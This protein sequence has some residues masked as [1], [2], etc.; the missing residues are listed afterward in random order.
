MIEREKVLAIYMEGHSSD[1]AGKMGFG[2]LRYSA[3]PVACVVDSQ[4]A[5]RDAAEVTGIPRPCPI[6]ATIAEARARGAEVLVLGIAPPGGRIPAAWL[7]ALDAAVACGFSL[8]NGLHDRLGPR[9]PTLAA[10][11]WVWDIRVEPPG[12]GIA[13]GAAAKST[14]RRVV[15]VGTDMAI[16]K[17]TA[18]LELHAAALAR[19]L[20]SHFVATGQIGITITGRGVPLDAIRL[21]FA[22]GAVE[23]EVLAAGD[24]AIVF[25]E[26]QGSLLHPAS[27]ATLPLLRGAMPTHLVLCHRA[28]QTHLRRLPE[29]VIP[30]LDRVIALYR[31]VAAACGAFP[32]PAVPCVALNTCEVEADD[33]ARRAADAI[34]RELGLPCDDPLRHGPERLLESLLA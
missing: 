25:V 19:G 1:S 7:A 20:R 30:P 10:G 2:V 6:V 12:L 9:Y 31:D 14:A 8:V 32:R 11:Q 33:D 22:S 26:G 4:A 24:A 27:S 21:D 17:M 18:G 13:T 34:E 5:G 28:G 23:R 29:I 3:N 15:L 16:G